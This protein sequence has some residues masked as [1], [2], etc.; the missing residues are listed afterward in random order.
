M[1]G[2]TDCVT[3]TTDA[4]HHQHDA[5]DPETQ[6]SRPLLDCCSV[7]VACCLLSHTIAASQERIITHDCIRVVSTHS[8]SVYNDCPIAFTPHFA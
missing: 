2:N 3:R 6:R 7:G 8:R 4:S 1:V 5:A